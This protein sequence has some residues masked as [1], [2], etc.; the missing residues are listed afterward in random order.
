[1]IQSESRTWPAVVANSKSVTRRSWKAK[2]AAW[3]QKGRRF[4]CYDRVPFQNG[5][6]IAEAVCTATAY[7]EPL[8]TMP[9]EDWEREGFKWMHEHPVAIPEKA[10]DFTWAMLDCAFESFEEWRQRSKHVVMWVCRFEIVHVEDWAVARLSD[11]LL[12]DGS[13]KA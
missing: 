1:M 7:Q 6:K 5:R 12:S 3:Y 13:I 2:T 10:R 8:G 11:I 9:D 4:D